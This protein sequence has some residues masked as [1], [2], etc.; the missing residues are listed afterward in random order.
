MQPLLALFEISPE[1]MNAFVMYV[2]SIVGGAVAGFFAG[3]F[4]AKLF[5]RVVLGK[6]RRSADFLHRLFRSLLALTV[7]VLVA[8]FL[9]PGGGG[10]RGTGEGKDD[11]ALKNGSV[12]DGTGGPDPKATPVPVLPP[13]SQ[14]LTPNEKAI[15]LIRLE[16][17]G[18]SDL[19]A[20]T[21]FYRN[22][23]TGEQLT[24]AG[25]E[26]L[27]RER[28]ASAKPGVGVAIEYRFTRYSSADFQGT[29][30]LLNWANREKLTTKPAETSGQ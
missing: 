10:G 9:F 20:G 24:L 13:E 12:L 22:R 28:K 30:T 29:T 1:R 15:E 17:L 14:I 5:D 16:I 23:D 8:I 25:V 4:L 3:I 11:G 26:K 27:V 6:G 7:A 18:G 21:D 2:L 19:K